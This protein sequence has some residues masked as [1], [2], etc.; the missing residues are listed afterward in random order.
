MFGKINAKTVKLLCIFETLAPKRD[1]ELMKKE[2]S[3]VITKELSE[4]ILVL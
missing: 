4:R 3:E 2:Y 1:I